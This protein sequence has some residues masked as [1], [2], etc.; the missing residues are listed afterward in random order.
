MQG[1]DVLPCNKLKRAGGSFVQPPVSVKIQDRR[2]PRHLNQVDMPLGARPGGVRAVRATRATRH[3][4]AL[5]LGS[6]ALVAHYPH[7]RGGRRHDA[8][9][10]AQHLMATTPAEM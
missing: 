7:H 6:D 1:A 9:A 3:A 10:R 8:T 2:S 4:A 5:R